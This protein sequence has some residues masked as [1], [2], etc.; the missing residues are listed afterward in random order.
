MPPVG[1][2]AYGEIVNKLNDG[3]EPFGC[4]GFFDYAQNDEAGL[5]G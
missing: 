4:V 2:E 1:Q 3:R 5:S